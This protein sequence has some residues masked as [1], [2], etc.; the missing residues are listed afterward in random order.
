MA[1]FRL[2]L[3]LDRASGVLASIVAQLARQGVELKTQK[4]TRAAE[5]RGGSLDILAEG[6]AG[7]IAEF[8]EQMAAARGVDHVVSIERDGELVF[9]DGEVIEPEPEV[10]PEPASDESIDAEVDRFLEPDSAAGAVDRERGISDRQDDW[11]EEDPDAAGPSALH[12]AAREADEEDS[13]PMLGRVDDPGPTPAED[14]AGLDESDDDARTNRDESPEPPE[15]EQEPEPQGESDRAAPNDDDEPT[16][17]GWGKE[18]EAE[19]QSGLADPEP[20][21]EEEILLGTEPGADSRSLED[22]DEPEARKSEVQTDDPAPSDA[23]SVDQEKEPADRSS[24]EAEA[25][26]GKQDDAEVGADSGGADRDESDDEARLDEAERTA[27]RE[28]DASGNGDSSKVGAT[29]R[30]RRRRRR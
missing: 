29:L 7:D 16:E 23:P 5:G 8:A 12:P 9:A 6:E 3:E 24:D 19:W 27:A 28:P 10:L 4:L 22:V 20:E 21:E 11:L 15:S 17:S 18:A 25:G 1:A 30:R 2:K 14:D 26:S 13:S